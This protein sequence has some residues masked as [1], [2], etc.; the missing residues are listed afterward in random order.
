MSG[1]SLTVGPTSPR[2]SHA[3]CIVSRAREARRTW[4]TPYAFIAPFFVMF[5]AFGVYPLI[6]A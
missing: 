1:S 3:A 5:L 2:P 4:W 6:Y